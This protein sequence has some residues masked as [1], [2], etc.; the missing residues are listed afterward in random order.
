MATNIVIFPKLSRI[1]F[2]STNDIVQD[3]IQTAAGAIVVSGSTGT[4]SF[5]NGALTLSSSVTAND[6]YAQAGSSGGVIS[7]RSGGALAS[8]YMEVIKPNGTRL[9]FIGYD[10]TNLLY[11]AENGA[12]HV[13]Q[14]G[15][16]TFSSSVQSTD[17][18]YTAN[19]FLTYDTNATGTNIMQIRSGY[20][21]AVLSFDGLGA[22]TF[23]SSVT[24]T[25]GGGTF[26]NSTNTAGGFAKLEISSNA[27]SVA[28]LSFTN[29]LSIT[30]GPATF[31]SSVTA[32]GAIF[33]GF[34]IGA[35]PISNGTGATF[36]RYLNS[37]GDFY[38]GIENSASSFFGATAYANVMYM[39]STNLEMFWSGAK[40]VTITSAGAATFSSSVTV[41]G[42]AFQSNIT[43]GGYTLDS[44]G[45][46]VTLADGSFVDFP[47]MSGMIIVNNTGTGALQVFICGGGNTA[48]LGNVVN[49]TGTMTHSPG[50]GGYRFTNNTGSSWA[51]AFQV[52]RTRGTA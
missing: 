48:S 20:A 41:T 49:V 42:G 39:G 1:A 5:N 14:G 51:F 31:S 16:A 38:M 10:Q 27:T 4:A 37:G 30:G 22:A 13:F 45:S 23:S 6:V 2:T 26:F 15:A 52:F 7:L 47:A 40:R 34:A 35:N 12:S 43:P 36:T 32:T 46:F 3:I 8:G 24:S 9:G 50:V 18:R 29:S 11:Q 25:N 33:N 44:A 17:F 21:G 28:T 19:G